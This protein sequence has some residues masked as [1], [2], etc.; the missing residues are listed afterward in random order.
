MRVIEEKE[1]TT[2]S[3][4]LRIH[5]ET[6]TVETITDLLRIEPDRFVVKGTKA[7]PNN[8]KSYVHP[9]N[10]WTLESDLKQTES[11]EAHIT[12]IV[13]FIESRLNAFEK[14]IKTC[15]IDI[16]CGYFSVN[17]TGFLS[18]SPDL[19]KRL[20]VMPV[21]IIVYLYLPDD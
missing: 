21:K 20:T 12:R 1:E 4:V 11:F 15:E 9:A 16:Y 3:V 18:L 7:V 8:P 17:Y 10:M 2:N 14:L 6:T 19:L 13:E 5:S